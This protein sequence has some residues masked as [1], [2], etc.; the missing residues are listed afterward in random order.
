M[1]LVHISDRVQ[2]SASWKIYKQGFQQNWIHQNLS[3]VTSDM[4][5]VRKIT[6]YTRLIRSNST[7]DILVLDQ[8]HKIDILRSISHKLESSHFHKWRNFGEFISNWD[9]AGN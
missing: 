2:T 8:F 7:E 1:Y 5:F 9:S 3:P 6:H 4:D